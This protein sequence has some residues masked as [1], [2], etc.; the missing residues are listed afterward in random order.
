MS[1]EFRKFDGT[2]VDLVDYI[3]GYLENHNDVEILVGTDSQNRGATTVFCT[4]VAL[5]HP[6]HG[7]HCIYRKWK[8]NRFR[9][10]EMDRRLMKEVE[11]SIDTAQEIKNNCWDEPKYI[12]LDINPDEEAGS[13]IV[14]QAAMGYVK[15]MGYECR[16][17]TLGPLITT[18]ADYVVKH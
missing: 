10:Y 6:G 9:K 16:F 13:N 4:V 3:N 15:G 1:V 2:V 7:A 18:L 8:T 12:D 17:K 11:A 14:F 5:Y